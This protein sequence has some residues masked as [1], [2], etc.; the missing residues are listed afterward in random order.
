MAAKT[1]TFR[2]VGPALEAWQRFL[3]RCLV[4]VVGAVTSPNLIRNRT[5]PPSSNT[6]QP[7]AA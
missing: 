5:G 4:L 3:S 2:S 7:E 6:A 1:D